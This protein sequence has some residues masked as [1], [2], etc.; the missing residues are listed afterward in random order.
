MRLSVELVETRSGAVLWGD[1][2]DTSGPL[3]FNAQDRIASSIVRTLVPRLREAELRRSRG[4]RAE[5]LSAYHL[6]LQA[7][8][9]VFRLERPAFE[10]AGGLLREALSRDAGYAPSYAAMADWYS[11]RIGQGW[12]SDPDADIRALEGAARLAIDLDSGNGRALAMLAHNRTILQRKYD[13][14]LT[15]IE[16]AIEA[17]PN[18]AEA[19]MW[20]S[21]T[22]AYVGSPSEARHRAER[23]IA[24]SPRD[25]F[26]FR[27]EHFMCI[28]HYA[29]DEY[30]EAAYW[31]MRSLRANPHYTSNL[32]M[33]AAALAGL[34]RATEARPL[35]DKV[36]ELEP[37]FRVSVMIPRQAFRDPAR[38]NQY[39][40]H[41]VDA[42][43]PL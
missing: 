10:K 1:A 14:A 2:Y 31:G 40:R 15:L 33:T 19:L 5:D 4:Q 8:E 21:P 37:G 29:A 22:Y 25:P 26:L 17:S 30:E 13:D 23:A 20:S 12:S 27:Y 35:V 34:G 32:R 11:I 39:G 43:L 9:L 24:L 28:A 3:F 6:M 7:R 38:R 18:D 36:K 16:R 42:G 41:L